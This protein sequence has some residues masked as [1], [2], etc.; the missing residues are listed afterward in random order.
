MMNAPGSH[1]VEQLGSQSL[2][3]WELKRLTS[4]ILLVG[5]N[6]LAARAALPVHGR[7]KPCGRVAAG[8]RQIS[9]TPPALSTHPENRRMLGPLSAIGKQSRLHPRIGNDTS[10]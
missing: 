3:W 6:G 2:G 10:A 8:E 4:H 5:S 7:Q 9:R 1:G